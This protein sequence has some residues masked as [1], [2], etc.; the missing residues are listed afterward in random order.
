[1]HLCLVTPK[2]LSSYC[3]NSL[4]TGTNT[5]TFF[6]MCWKLFDQKLQ[7]FAA[8]KKIIVVKMFVD[9]PLEW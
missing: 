4:S 9:I 1:M 8:I 5:L 6:S 7:H 2:L 3:E